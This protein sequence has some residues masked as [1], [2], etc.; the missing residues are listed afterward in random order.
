MTAVIVNVPQPAIVVDADGEL[1]Q[2]CFANQT[3]GQGAL[4]TALYFYN[5]LILIVNLYLAFRARKAG[6][7][8]KETQSIS[9]VIA[10]VLLTLSLAIPGM[11]YILRLCVISR[12]P[13]VAG[14]LNQVLGSS[15]APP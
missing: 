12:S 8:F 11:K 9:M 1:T 2:S 3:T 13:V 7:L 14:S 4:I 5:A 6:N 10:I 15:H